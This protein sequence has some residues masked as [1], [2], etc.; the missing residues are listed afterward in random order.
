MLVRLYFKIPGTRDACISS[1][2]HR[3]VVLAVAVHI[4]YW[5]MIVS[6]VVKKKYL[7]LKTQVRLKSLSSLLWRWV[8][9]LW[10]LVM[11]AVGF[12]VLVVTVAI[13]IV[14]WKYLLVE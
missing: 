11:E 13:P 3:H 1:P 4:V 14:Y 10:R 8:S 6:K 7:R 9:L 5:E 2:C 12:I